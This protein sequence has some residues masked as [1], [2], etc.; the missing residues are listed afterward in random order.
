MFFPGAVSASAG[1]TF[2]LALALPVSASALDHPY[3]TQALAGA[4]RYDPAAPKPE[5][6]VEKPAAEPAG[7]PRRRVSNPAERIPDAKPRAAAVASPTLYPEGTLVLPKMTVPGVKPPASARL[8]QLHTKAPV[9]N[10]GEGHIFETPK[11]RIER[12]IKKYY[13][14]NEQGL[15]RLLLNSVGGWAARDAA[16]NDSTSQLND[17]AYLIELSL[18]AG[19]E[20]AEEQEEIRAEYYRLLATKPR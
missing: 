20:S 19:L 18:A 4:Y 1:T 9:R 16:I 7:R 15:G 13:T 5:P 6:V 12:L 8:P 10:V 17:L 11:G 3:R 2:V 14:T